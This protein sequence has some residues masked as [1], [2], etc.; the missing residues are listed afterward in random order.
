MKLSIRRTLLG[1]LACLAL[2]LSQAGLAEQTADPHKVLRYVFIAAEDGFDPAAVRDL[3]SAHIVQSIFETLY[4]YDYLARPAKLVP[5]TAE[6]LPEISP[7]GKTY[8][9]HLKKG[10]YFQ[11]DPAFRGKLRELTMADYV[12]SFKRLLDPRLT[13]AHTWLWDGEV[14]GLDELVAEGKKTGHYDI[15]KPVTGFEL[16]DR[17]TLRIHLKRSDF[18]LGMKLA[19]EPNSAVARE[20]IEKYQDAQGQVMANPVGTGPYK[21]EQ[22]VRGSR[23]V[24]VANPGY[25][26]LTWDFQ[27]GDDPDDQQIVA[28]M[29][30]KR[31]PQI[32]RIEISV[33][34]EDQS[35]LLAF[36]KDEVDLFQ[37]EGPL[38]PRVIKDGKLRAEYVKMGAQLSRIVDPEISYFYWN[39]SDPVVG[40]L[41]K[42][43]IALRR[44]MAMAHDVDDELKMVYNGEAVALDYP[45]PPGVVGYDPNYKSS[46]QHDTA[47]A[48]MLLDKFGY[49]IGGDGWRTLPDGSPLVIR[50]T[51]YNNSRGAMQLES[52]KK[53]FDSIHIRM[54]DNRSQYEDILKAEKNCKLQMRDSP[55][56]A[57]YPDG[58]NFMQLFYGPNSG[59]NNAGCSKIPEF[60][61]L[62]E[63]T[64]AMPA[65]PERD[66]LYHKMTRILEVY[67]PLRM[68]YARVRNMLAQSRLIGYKKHPILHCE[69]LYFDIDKNK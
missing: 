38:A 17:Y 50:S 36:Q 2:C 3:Y 30:G 59:S 41:S 21:L 43:K 33:M 42:E 6:S 12:Y 58:D 68:G 34:L 1:V 31:M 5:Q 9:I 40:G 39:M 8:T 23:I 7:D 19:H 46:I 18:N 15:G 64:Q 63:Q 16:L 66:L 32:G 52:W 20:V 53:T 62:Y 4:T 60:D 11:E 29:K 67:T 22:W 65:G 47:A 27:P 49:K 14:E 25:R 26:G 13:S 28:Q 54:E 51:A 69:W 48:N 10:I 37:L 24:L 56:D 45:I 44:A 55:W 57:D 61:R 35:R